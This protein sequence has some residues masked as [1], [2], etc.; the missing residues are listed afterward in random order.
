MGMDLPLNFIYWETNFFQYKIEDGFKF[1]KKKM[2]L[3]F[4]W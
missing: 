4:Q 3:I 2:G 1:N